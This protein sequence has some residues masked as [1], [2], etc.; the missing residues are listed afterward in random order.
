MASII[1]MNWRGFVYLL[2]E[3]VI[4][5]PSY[6]GLLLR[7]IASDLGTRLVLYFVDP[8]ERMKGD[9]DLGRIWTYMVLVFIAFRFLDTKPTNSIICNITTLFGEKY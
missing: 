6:K 2:K 9:V 5:I 4:C 1:T 7:L 8:L 3:L